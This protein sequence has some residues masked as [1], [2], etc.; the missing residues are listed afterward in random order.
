MN[1]VYNAKPAIWKEANRELEHPSKCESINGAGA[2]F[3]KGFGAF[4]K[5]RAGGE[6]IVD[7]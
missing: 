3:S 4:M 1:E 2:S 6:D 5:G 7:Q